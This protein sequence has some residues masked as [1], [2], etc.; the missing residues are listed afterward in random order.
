MLIKWRKYCLIFRLNSCRTICFN[1]NLYRFINHWKYFLVIMTQHQPI[2]L[3]G[4]MRWGRMGYFMGVVNIQ[5]VTAVLVNLVLS[6]SK[7]HKMSIEKTSH[8]IY[9]STPFELINGHIAFI[10][11]ILFVLTLFCPLFF[12]S[13]ISFSY[14]IH[15]I[16]MGVVKKETYPL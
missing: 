3:V 12:L 2:L 8:N 7:S 11:Y 10:K 16:P 15:A 13:Y 9:L 1:T 14:H 5:Q 4:G 6:F